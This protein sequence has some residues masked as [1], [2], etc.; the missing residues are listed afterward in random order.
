MSSKFLDLELI[1]TDGGRVKVNKF[2]LEKHSLHMKDALNGEPGITELPV[3]YESHTISWVWESLE[4]KINIETP[5]DRIAIYKLAH[6]WDCKNLQNTIEQDLLSSKR[7]ITIEELNVMKQLNSVN[8]ELGIRKFAITPN[9]AGMSV[10]FGN[11]FLAYIHTFLDSLKQYLIHIPGEYVYDPVRTEYAKK[12]KMKI[13]DFANKPKEILSSKIISQMKESYP[14]NYLK[15]IG[16]Y[17]LHSE[18]LIVSLSSD[19]ELAVI[20]FIRYIFNRIIEII[21]RPVDLNIIPAAEDLCQL[22]IGQY[23]P[24][25]WI[26][27]VDRA[28]FLA[29]QT[30]S[31]ARRPHL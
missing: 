24:H 25:R 1:G 13:L 19:S 18:E 27:N 16:R 8:F 28:A 2:Q 5:N 14:I 29:N 10:M 9:G 31:R 30:A 20:K 6:L 23:G 12:I 26:T 3:P 22:K 11:D 21:T 15:H 7:P 17:M 4:S